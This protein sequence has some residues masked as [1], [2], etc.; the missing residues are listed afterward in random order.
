MYLS[1]IE[2]CVNLCI[3][4]HTSGDLYSETHVELIACYD[5]QSVVCKYVFLLL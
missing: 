4:S 1:R 5:S 2:T 3:C